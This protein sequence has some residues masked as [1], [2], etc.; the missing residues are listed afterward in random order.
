MGK[1]KIG[2]VHSSSMRWPMSRARTASP[3]KDG[4]RSV[5]AA[6]GVQFVVVVAGAE[7]L[8]RAVVLDVVLERG[9]AVGSLGSVA[10]GL[11]ETLGGGSSSEGHGDGAEGLALRLAVNL[12]RT[13]AVANAA[14]LQAL[15]LGGDA[16]DVALLV[17]RRVSRCVAL[18]GRVQRV[19][20]VA[21]LANLVEGRGHDLLARVVT[22]GVVVLALPVVA[23]VRGGRRR[24]R[25]ARCWG[26]SAALAGRAHTIA[27]T[28]AAV[29]VR[30]ALAA[31]C[32]PESHAVPAVAVEL[33]LDGIAAAHLELL[34]GEPLRNVQKN[35][36]TVSYGSKSFVQH[37]QALLAV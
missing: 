24:R 10:D 1:K 4:G 6:L 23:A 21:I 17:A 33:A 20:L 34:A 28:A 19:Q 14:R 30:A 18:H 26:D 35:K 9:L 27:G 37:I 15:V 29:S 36:S 25:R 22:R 3:L 2:I 8:V 16:A 13:A 7:L 31:R 11:G 5:V 12:A 32:A